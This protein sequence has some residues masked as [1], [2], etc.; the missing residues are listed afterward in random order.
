[1]D[2]E[3]DD[4]MRMLEEQ[5]NN[6][7]DEN[8]EQEPTDVTDAPEVNTNETEVTIGD[9][10]DNNEEED[11]TDSPD[12]GDASPGFNVSEHFDGY[13]SIDQVKSVIERGKQ[14]TPEIE[15][16]ITTLRQGAKDVDKLKTEVEGLRNRQPFKNEKFYQ[17]DQLSEKDPDK[18]A[19]YQRFMFGE[20][21]DEE[22]VKLRM[23][24]DH[25]KRFKENPGYINRQITNKYSDFLGDEFTSEDPEYMDAKTALGLDADSARQSFNDEIGKIEVPKLKSDE[26]KV[27]DD[28][29]FFQSW[30]K[31]FSEVKTQIGKIEVP[32]LDEKDPT[33]T[34]G[35]MDYDI[36]ESELKDIHEA[37]ANHI[38]SQRLEPTP[39]NVKQAKDVALGLYL[40]KNLAKVNTAFANK[41]TKESGAKWRKRINNP[42]KSG[43]DANNVNTSQK[44]P[45]EGSAESIFNDIMQS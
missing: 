5:G 21:S 1:M 22:V 34:V 15:T 18:A 42:Q 40:L 27:A 32:V 25:P 39:E 38:F 41:I 9:Q 44:G 12:S 13:E 45:T 6:V 14:Y 2:K 30:Q 43:A 35:F 20:N 26:D 36:P 17:L 10:E 24:L 28:K 31:P 11:T 8:I 37:A 19:I 23:M 29:A 7:P 33:K 16:E 3:Q 4:I